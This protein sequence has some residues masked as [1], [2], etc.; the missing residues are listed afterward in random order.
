MSNATALHELSAKIGRRADTSDTITV[1][2][3]SSPEG[4]PRYNRLL[5][6]ARAAA[7]N[8]YLSRIL[9]TKRQVRI[10]HHTTDSSWQELGAMVI[11]DNHIPSKA[12]VLNILGQSA[13]TRTI[14]E[15]L[16]RVGNGRAWSYIAT[17]LLPHLCY[18]AIYTPQQ[19]SDSICTIPLLK[20][21]DYR[22]NRQ[23]PV[24]TF[25]RV[26]LQLP[27]PP[28]ETFRRSLFAVKTNLLFDAATI[29]NVEFEIPIRQRWSIA[30]EWVF[31]W[32]KA[33]N[34]KAD[35]R[36]NRLQ[37]L[38]GNIEGRYWFGNRTDRPQL[39]G[40]F[41]GIYLGGGLYDI[42]HNG[43]GYQGEFFIMG[44]LSG[45]YAHTINKSGSLRMEYSLGVGYMQTDY[46]KYKAVYCVDNRWHA[47][48]Q[49]SGDYVW[50]GPTKAKISLVW[51]INSVKK[52]IAK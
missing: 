17:H 8:Q 48:R 9:S 44:G 30:A 28:A 51:M 42:E 26:V 3:A 52:G 33:D 29:L 35:S 12:E 5:T 20:L 46:R 7:V 23:S 24:L 39:T 19:Q 16:R 15:E 18:G 49:S 50:I 2:I 41:A 14:E 45:G 13:N 32:W 36:R 34:G 1:I 31:P 40:W 11:V 21:R 25:E 43:T 6:A 37:I 10:T 38:N 4:N 22:T 27:E 47:I